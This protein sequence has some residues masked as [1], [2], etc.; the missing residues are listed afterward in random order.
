MDSRI[1]PARFPEVDAFVLAGGASSRMGSDKSLLLLN[2]TPQA[3]RTARLLCPLVGR[4]ALVLRDSVPGYEG[5]RVVLEGEVLGDELARSDRTAGAVWGVAAALAAARTEWSLIVACDLPF[6]T[7]DWLAYLISR[8]LD[9]QADMILPRDVLCMACHRRCK[10]TLL[11]ELD[12]ERPRL[13]R[14]MGKLNV[15][16]VTEE[17]WRP[18][19]ADGRL[20]FNMNRPEDYAA[21]QDAIDGHADML[22]RA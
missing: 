15:E 20:F 18:F 19:A 11:E 5:F 1:A 10:G 9:S 4:V 2:E 8:T 7:D 22:G 14:A 21:A 12:R 17:E 13:G 16:K 3:L 6:L